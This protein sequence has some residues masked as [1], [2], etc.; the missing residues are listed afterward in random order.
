MSKKRVEVRRIL[1]ERIWGVLGKSIGEMRDGR[2]T[3]PNQSIR[4]FLE[5]V[6]YLVRTGEPWRDLPA[7]LGHW[8]SV[9]CRF[10]RWEKAGYWEKL[11][12]GLSQSERQEMRT[13]FID[14]TTVRAHQHA[15]GAPKKTARIRLLA[16]LGE[17]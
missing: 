12:Q 4:D 2:G 13:L 10:R 7:Q 6:L 14:S 3:R 11:W 15:A 9:Y 16:A 8:H 1:S 5:S 17:V